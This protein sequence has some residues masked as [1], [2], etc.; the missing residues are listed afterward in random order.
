[1]LQDNLILKHVLPA[2][3][4]PFTAVFLRKV[5]EGAVVVVMVFQSCKGVSMWVQSEEVLHGR[6]NLRLKCP[7]VIENDLG[8]DA[9]TFK[10]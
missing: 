4:I 2:G 7:M 9:Q 1:M 6:L 8:Q 3:F 10:Y 5:E